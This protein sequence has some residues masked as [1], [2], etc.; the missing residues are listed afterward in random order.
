MATGLPSATVLMEHACA[1]EE[2]ASLPEGDVVEHLAN[3]DE[4]QSLRHQ[5]RAMRQQP[6]QCLLSAQTMLQLCGFNLRNRLWNRLWTCH[7][8]SVGHLAGSVTG[9][10]LALVNA[11]LAG[12]KQLMLEVGSWSANYFFASGLVAQQRMMTEASA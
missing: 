1:R 7:V 12:L 6:Q 10:P 8:P 5:L 4:V 9:N 2:G 11:T 3:M